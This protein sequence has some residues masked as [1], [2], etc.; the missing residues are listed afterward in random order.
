[1]KK[2]Y[3][4][5]ILLSVVSVLSFSVSAAETWYTDWGY[6]SY[7]YGYAW[8]T[9]LSPTTPYLPWGANTIFHGHRRD[10]PD[11]DKYA[12]PWGCYIDMADAQV[13]YIYYIDISMNVRVIESGGPYYSFDSPIY[14]DYDYRISS[15]AP[16][17]GDTYGDY[18]SL[19]QYVGNGISVSCE[20]GADNRANISITVSTTYAPELIGNVVLLTGLW[21]WNQES[22][23]VLT[24]GLYMSANNVGI[25]MQADPDGTYYQQALIAN[26]AAGNAAAAQYYSD[27]LAKLDAIQDAGSDYIDVLPTAEADQLGSSV[28]AISS[29]EGALQ[30]SAS[31]LQSEVSSDWSDYKSQSVSAVS[32]LQPTAL[33]VSDLYIAL[34]DAMPTEVRALLFVIPIILFFGF[35]IG[36]LQ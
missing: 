16:A 29:A 14:G 25:S 2:L 19:Q 18:L 30:G 23:D 8:G 1:M 15:I 31:E 17:L 10:I 11:D 32:S 21:S 5:L 12:T 20:I 13:G 9:A 34:T 27:S 36:R 28:A 33:A 3:V 7:G 6:I 22:A 24:H 35:L 4:I 26:I